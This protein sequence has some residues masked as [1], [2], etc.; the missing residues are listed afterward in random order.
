MSNAKKLVDQMLH[1]APVP[2][3]QVGNPGG[4]GPPIFKIVKA[5]DVGISDEL[6]EFL[7]EAA[8]DGSIISIA[9]LTYAE[10]H[11]DHAEECAR[12]ADL[13]TKLGVDYILLT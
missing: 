7:G 4:G 12:L 2:P 13:M 8:D 11:S 1:E 9:D 3:D 10:D 5:E 6:T